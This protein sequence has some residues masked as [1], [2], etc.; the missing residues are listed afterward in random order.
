MI[1]P[2]ELILVE[3]EKN[4]SLQEIVVAAKH[5]NANYNVFSV[6][7]VLW[8][9]VKAA[10]NPAYS[11]IF[12]AYSNVIIANKLIN[13][14][15]LKYYPSERAVKYALVD[16]LKSKHDTVIFEMP[17]LDSRIDVGRINGNS[18]AY[19][20]KTDLDSLKRI[21][22]QIVDYSQ[23]FEYITLIIAPSFLEE[24]LAIAPSHCGIWTY[25]HNQST[26]KITFTTKR[27]A[28][29]SPH[30][31]P[32]AQLQCLSQGSLLQILKDKKIK[33]IPAKKDDRIKLITALYAPRTINFKFKS[34][35][36][37]TYDPHW[38]FV[39]KR[40]S[41]ILPIDLQAIFKSLIEPTLVYAK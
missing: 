25:S 35:V 33:K 15:I 36:Q 1:S 16:K 22:K 20:I 28:K 23:I 27:S 29:K 24:T 9:E 7:A 18:F 31:C 21:E 12:D 5:L 6:D 39:R 34:A 14:L 41:S 4:V 38:D 30:I 37:E 19:E 2:E 11:Q 10:F 8:E 40:Y 17:V 13:L 3:I 32:N 26:G